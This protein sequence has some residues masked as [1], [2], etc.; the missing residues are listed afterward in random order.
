MS[1]PRVLVIDDT[2]ENLFT[3]GVAL[4]A[5][6]ELQ[7]ATSGEMGLSLASESLPDLVLLDVMM[8]G[9]DGFEVCRRLKENPLLRDTPVLFVTALAEIE[10]ESEGLALGAADYI[11]KPVNVD[12]ARQRIRNL[13]DRE[14]LRKEVEAHRDQLEARVAERTLALSI[15]KEAAEA[16]SRAKTI[17][18]ANM[19]HELRTPMTGIMGTLQ[20]ASRRTTDAKVRELLARSLASANRLM[21]ILSDI[22]DMSEVESGRLRLES[23]RFLPADVIEQLTT[24]AES[25]A[26][27]KGLDLA[28]EVAPELNGLACLGDELRLGQILLTL[29]SNAIKFTPAGSVSLRATLSEETGDQVRLRFEV[30]DS[31]IGISAQDQQ[32]LFQPF[33]QV[34]GSST[35]EYGG[36]G[37]G[38]AISRRLAQLMAGDIGVTSEAG[39][40]SVFWCTVRLPKEGREA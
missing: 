4:A 7:I 31:G 3:L 9:M 26:R 21:A 30:K 27:E 33:E 12:N 36:T 28:V 37:L 10:S 39:V 20:L 14:R 34:D 6:F 18:L 11:V 29:T 35:R 13:L 2:P 1:K 19:S 17:F 15:A 23:R 40:G 16:A 32:R 24:R 25:A 38:L 8:P 22:I 5:E